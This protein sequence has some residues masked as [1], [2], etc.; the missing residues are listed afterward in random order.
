[1]KSQLLAVLFM[2]QGP[3]VGDLPILAVSAAHNTLPA[4]SGSPHK[5]YSIRAGVG[6]ILDASSFGFTSREAE[7][8]NGV[9]LVR[10]SAMYLE[11]ELGIEGIPTVYGRRWTVGSGPC[12]LSSLTLKP[13]YG[14]PAFGP[15]RVGELLAVAIGHFNRP[16]D[17]GGDFVPLWAAKVEVK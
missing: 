10:G 12:V 13:I 9:Q 16:G 11:G 2:M 1:M 14:S 5:V 15:L 7:S 3:S 4:A 8:V 6:L 17:K